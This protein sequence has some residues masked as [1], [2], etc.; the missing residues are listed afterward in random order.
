MLKSSAVAIVFSPLFHTLGRAAMIA[1]VL[2]LFSF[3][4]GPKEEHFNIFLHQ[5]SFPQ[6]G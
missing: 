5:P 4:M 2:L 6:T 3:L 1:F